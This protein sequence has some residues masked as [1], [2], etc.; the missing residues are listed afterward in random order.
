MWQ[1]CRYEDEENLFKEMRTL[2]ETYLKKMIMLHI[3]IKLINLLWKLKSDKTVH[4]SSIVL[5]YIYQKQIATL[6]DVYGEMSSFK[7]SNYF[8][9]K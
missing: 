8:V 4:N 3:S 9:Y 6:K 7:H 5:F 1:V 2:Q